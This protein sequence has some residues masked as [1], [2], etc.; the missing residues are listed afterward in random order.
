MVAAPELV[1][2]LLPPRERALASIHFKAEVVLVAGQHLAH[3]QGAEGA[4][5]E[6]QRNYREILAGDLHGLQVA[7]AFTGEGLR[8][9]IA[10]E[11]RW[12]DCPHLRE[13]GHDAR[14][15]DV[16]GEVAPVG[17]NIGERGAFA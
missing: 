3:A 13:D 10:A 1:L 6:A 11:A 2:L 4:V 12:D 9:P 14:A 15:R 5:A 17:A 8:C 7:L 16:F